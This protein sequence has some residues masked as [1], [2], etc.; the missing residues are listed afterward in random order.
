MGGS[1]RKA[2]GR[3]FYYTW[4]K[5][6]GRKYLAEN[7]CTVWQ[8]CHFAAA[9]P[10]GAFP[11]RRR[12]AVAQQFPLAVGQVDPFFFFRG[13]VKDAER[14]PCRAVAGC[15]GQSPA[16]EGLFQR[17][18]LD[19]RRAG[20][21]RGAQAGELRPQAQQAPVIVHKTVELRGPLPVQTVE[22]GRRAVGV[23]LTFFGAGELLTGL[24][25][26]H[27][28]AGEIDARRQP[29][30]GQR[31]RVGGSVLGTGVPDEHQLVPESEIVVG[32]DIADD[33]GGRMGGQFVAAAP[34]G[35]GP[36]DVPEAARPALDVTRL[37][38]VKTAA[39][40]DVAGVVAEDADA[41]GQHGEVR[42]VGL[43]P[44]E[45]AP[46]TLPR[47]T[48]H[49]DASAARQSV[50]RGPQF[51]HGVH[52]IEAH[53]VEAEA[54]DVIFLRPVEHRVDEVF[55][56]HG[57]LT[58]K[59]VAAAAAVGEAAV[60]VLPE[61]IIR[62]RAVQRVLAAVHMIVHHVHDDAD[63]RRVE[64]GYHLL[65]LP[66]PDFA[67]RG[68]GG[69]AALGDVVVG[70]V[71][72]PV[73][74]PG[75]GAA[76]VHTAEVE[77]GHQLHIAHFQPLEIVEAGGEG[78]GGRKG[79]SLLGKGHEFAPPCIPNAAGR[80]L[81]EVTDADLPHRPARGRD[82]DP[83]VVAPVGRVDAGRV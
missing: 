66:H 79:G 8:Q 73:V 45:L 24:H 64:G 70:G 47:L 14:P 39:L 51:V 6:P 1:P 10:A 55:P 15:G 48:V 72:A 22:G 41:L 63:A 18:K 49:Q 37:P 54:V 57:P 26:G 33:L 32:R 67:F 25:E 77:D 16:H 31:C 12:Y 60:R 20:C 83:V 34:R 53:E 61:E 74:L 71:V 7:R 30:L 35:H 65:A 9:D 40:D 75:E 68:V 76:L 36:A 82:D 44:V 50:Q 21:V 13:I 11:E 43:V 17:E 81:R 2:A 78:A 38:G 3:F 69:V 59:L 46:A 23:A 42:L 27:P 5:I 62:H 19:G 4:P 80:V 56:G 58:G 28:H 52:V 29:V